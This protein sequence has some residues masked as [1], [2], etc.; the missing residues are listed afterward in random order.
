MTLRT[1]YDEAPFYCITCGLG[2]YEM[3]ACERT[4][5]E[6]EDVNEARRRAK[7]AVTIRD[8]RPP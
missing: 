5:C 6:R 8:N 4:D 7:A 1:P 2:F 3:M